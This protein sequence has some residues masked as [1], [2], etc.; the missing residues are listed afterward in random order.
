MGWSGG[1]RVFDPV[2]KKILDSNLTRSNKCSIIQELMEVLE[3]EDWDTFTDSAFCEDP[4]VL[5]AR[6]RLH[7]D[8]FE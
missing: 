3:D 5:A 1:Y 7:P 4:I 8:E 6:K 2:V